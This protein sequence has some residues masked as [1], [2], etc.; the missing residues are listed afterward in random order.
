M[1]RHSNVP[2]SSGGGN[3]YS[4][5]QWRGTVLAES[6]WR[7]KR[8]RPTLHKHS[9]ALTRDWELVVELI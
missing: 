2:A 9:L 1:Y 5:V 8:A 3:A 6:C 4:R 7:Q